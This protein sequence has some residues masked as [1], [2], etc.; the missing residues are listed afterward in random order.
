[1]QKQGIAL[2]EKGLWTKSLS[3]IYNPLHPDQFFKALLAG[4]RTFFFVY[5][6]FW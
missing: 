6:S 4:L 1:L 3:S 5:T 2:K